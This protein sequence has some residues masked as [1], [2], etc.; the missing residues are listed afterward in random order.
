MLVDFAGFFLFQVSSRVARG[1]LK[2]EQP[3]HHEGEER[4]AAGALG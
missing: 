3:H 4:T 1:L 2:G